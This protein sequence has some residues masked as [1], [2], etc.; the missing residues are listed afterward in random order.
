M[1]TDSEEIIPETVLHPL[2]LIIAKKFLEIYP[3]MDFEE[4]VLR[5]TAKSPEDISPHDREVFSRIHANPKEA[6]A[7][8]KEQLEQNHALAPNDSDRPT[9]A[10]NRIAT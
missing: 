7:Q 8:A 5:C 9:E 1:T 10:C 2:L 4:L 6:I 3:D